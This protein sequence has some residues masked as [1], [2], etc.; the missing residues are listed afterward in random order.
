MTVQ[1]EH[2]FPSDFSVL[3][4][5]GSR[6]SLADLRGAASVARRCRPRSTGSKASAKG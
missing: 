5:A 4:A 6:V 1:T 3:D 2:R